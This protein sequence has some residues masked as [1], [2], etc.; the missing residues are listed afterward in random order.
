MR[1]LG[2]GCER[3][4]GL[5]SSGARALPSRQRARWLESGNARPLV[6]I[7]NKKAAGVFLA[8]CLFLNSGIQCLIVIP[9]DGQVV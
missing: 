1:R 7:V 8:A 3:A 4:R 6:E 9:M 2:R 5:G